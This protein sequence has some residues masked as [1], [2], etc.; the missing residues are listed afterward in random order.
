[1]RASGVSL[2]QITSSVLKLGLLFVFSSIVVGELVSPWTE[3][4]AQ[5]GRAEALERNIEQKHS[6]GLWMRDQSTY[7][8]VGEVLP[9]SSPR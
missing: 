5:R 8:N 4:M 6:S 7:V 9:G 2:G 3:T 1:M